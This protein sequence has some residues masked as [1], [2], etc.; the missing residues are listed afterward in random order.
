M[1]SGFMES[2]C[3]ME[4]CERVNCLY[5]YLRHVEISQGVG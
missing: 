3:A 1:V 5:M 2:L 4:A